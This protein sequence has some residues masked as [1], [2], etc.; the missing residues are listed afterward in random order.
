MKKNVSI[1]IAIA[2]AT[3]AGCTNVQYKNTKTGETFSKTGFLMDAKI[4]SLAISKT[5]ETTGTLNLQG[6]NNSPDAAL[7]K[8]LDLAGAALKAAAIPPK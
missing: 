7:S 2:A 4:D 6:S 1:L 5:S 8:A 3:L